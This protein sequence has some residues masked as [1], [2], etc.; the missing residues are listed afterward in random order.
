MKNLVLICLLALA[1]PILYVLLIWFIVSPMPKA[2]GAI[3]ELLISIGEQYG[4]C[5][6]KDGAHCFFAFRNYGNA[7]EMVLDG[8]F[9]GSK[10][11][12]LEV[13]DAAR[14]AAYKRRKYTK[15]IREVQTTLQEAVEPSPYNAPVSKPAP[16]PGTTPKPVQ[17]FRD[18]LSDG[19]R[20]PEMV[21]IPAGNFTMGSPKNEKGRYNERQHQV[22]IKQ[23]FAMGKYE[24]AFEE[25]DR[26][27]E[28]TGRA[29]P[30][31]EDWGRGQRPVIN[32]DWHAAVAYAEWL[33]QETGQSYRLPT[34]AEWEYAAR[35]GT[36]TAYWWG[37]QIGR[38]KANCDG[39]GSRWDGKQTAP[40]GRFQANPFGLYDVHGNV[41]EWTCSEWGEVYEGQEKRCHHTSALRA[42]RGGSW[43]FGPRRVRSALRDRLE[44]SS[45][46]DFLGFRLARSL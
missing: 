16:A 37:N 42:I 2:S 35:A 29:T 17:V 5:E 18:T 43:N 41:W 20:G 46:L 4:D 3:D 22:H 30:S 39:C 14:K 7:R 31:D 24:V 13:L 45:R 8:K 1:A 15:W 27:V 9:E 34:E 23:A 6:Y 38:N 44:R 33:S 28:A 26:F 12:R 21:V 19:T 25:Y 11:E 10:E 36:Q 32:V 40:V